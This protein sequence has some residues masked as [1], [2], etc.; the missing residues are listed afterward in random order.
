MAE[1]R[2]Y[3]LEFGKPKKNVKTDDLDEL[4]DTIREDIGTEPQETKITV[5]KKRIIP[6]DDKPGWFG[7]LRWGK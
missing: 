6:D 4:M 2:K 5:R 1:K 3:K 7:R